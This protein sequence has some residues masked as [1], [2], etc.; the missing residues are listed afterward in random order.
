VN[1]R[2]V[3]QILIAD[4]RPI[5]RT[6]LRTILQ[7][8]KDFRVVGEAGDGAEALRLARRLKPDIL[9]LDLDMPKVS[10]MQVLRQISAERLTCRIIMLGTSIR[11]NDTLTAIQLGARGVVSKDTSAKL[12]VD[13][14]RWVMANR[15][16]IG[17]DRVTDLVRALQ[18]A[19]G[20]QED[21][22]DLNRFGLTER[23]RQVI[24]TILSGYTNKEIA[25]EFSISE[26][27][28]KRHLSNVFDKL[29]VSNRLELA[30]FAIHHKLGPE[31]LA[32]RAG[33][34]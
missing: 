1:K 26:E 2:A 19:E 31:E 4:D 8:E 28:V 23:E 27:T 29:G 22:S 24:A 9:L 6:G 10:G 16:W 12:L 30:L 7:S 13:S 34:P 25:K 17:R 21:A 18:T 5:F 33:D 14:I 32:G 20:S 3:I 11:E 15:Y